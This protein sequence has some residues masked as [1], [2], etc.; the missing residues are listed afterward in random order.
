[1]PGTTLAAT[2]DFN[3]TSPA[4]LGSEYSINL[5]IDKVNGIY[6]MPSADRTYA[7]IE[8]TQDQIYV[9]GDKISTEIPADQNMFRIENGTLIQYLGND[10]EIT[11][12]DG[13]VKIGKEAFI[14][15]ENITSVIIPDSVIEIDD[16]AFIFCEKLEVV[17]LPP[18]LE[19]IGDGAFAFCSSLYNIKIPD[20]VT[21]IGDS[22]FDSCVSLCEIYIPDSVTSIGQDAFNDCTSLTLRCYNTATAASYVKENRVNYRLIISGDTDDDGEINLNDLVC[23]NRLV[24]GANLVVGRGADANRDGVLNLNDLTLISRITNGATIA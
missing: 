13:V 21:E 12:P 8:Y 22:A 9:S 5:A 15:N 4:M 19:K 24:N 20:S 1:M 23:F 6:S 16:T 3:L 14:Q 2:I 17:V 11:I 18:A 7:E 10:N